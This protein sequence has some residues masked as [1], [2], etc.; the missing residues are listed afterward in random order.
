MRKKSV[1]QRGHIH[2]RG[3]GEKSHRILVVVS[4]GV[5]HGGLFELAMPLQRPAK[6]GQRFLNRYHDLCHKSGE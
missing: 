6:K 4:Q 1:M 5:G 3:L 2:V